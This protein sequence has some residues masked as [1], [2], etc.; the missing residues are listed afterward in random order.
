MGNDKIV[1]H[2]DKKV[3]HVEGQESLTGQEIKNLAE[4][5]IGDDRDL[6]LKM[7]GNEDDRLITSEETVQLENGMHF[8]SAPKNINPGRL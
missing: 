5:K 6:F 8:Y 4:P 2:I 3:Y 7:S 1:I